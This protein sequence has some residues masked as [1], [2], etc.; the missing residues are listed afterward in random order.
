MADRMAF[1][2]EDSYYE[3]LIEQQENLIDGQSVAI[4]EELE[5]RFEGKLY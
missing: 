3:W 2:D 1:S 4:D 5:D